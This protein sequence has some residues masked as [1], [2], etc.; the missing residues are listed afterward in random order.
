[1]NGAGDFFGFDR[2]HHYRDVVVGDARIADDLNLINS[3]NTL[4]DG[5][6]LC[7]KC[8]TPYR[9]IL[10]G[11][12]EEVRVQGVVHPFL[13]GTVERV[14]K[15]TEADYHRQGKHQCRYSR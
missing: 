2:N 11:R 12:N 13:D 15:P 10:T 4:D 3:V 1:M 7:R 8:E 9:E 5:A 14:C 6:D